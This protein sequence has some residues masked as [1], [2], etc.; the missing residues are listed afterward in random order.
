MPSIL[1]VPPAGEPITL[2]E[3]KLHLRVDFSEDDTLI[4]AL[5]TSARQTAEDI[6]RRAFI[7]QTW[8]LVLDQFPAPGV[9]IGSANWYG[10]QWGNSPGPLTTLRADG[11]TGF[12]IFLAHDPIVSVDSIAYI[13]QYGVTQTLASNQYKLD[14][15]SAPARILPAYGTTW[16][17]TRNEINAVTVTYT[18][19]YG[20][21][22]DVP[23][24]IKSWMKLRIGAMYENR[25]EIITGRGIVAKDMPFTDGLLASYRIQSF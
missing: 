6:T 21:A 4:Q 24:S 20:S 14:N 18:C 25:E 16:P 1:T 3:A 8:K 7:T 12:E 5:I 15:I 22:S 23:E 19:G 13:D 2:A 9:N 17:T 10:P 11:R